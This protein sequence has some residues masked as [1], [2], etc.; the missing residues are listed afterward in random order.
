MTLPTFIRF[1]IRTP[2]PQL[3]RKTTTNGRMEEDL[4]ILY[5]DLCNHWSDIP[6]IL[7]LSSVDQTKINNP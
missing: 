4:K 7:N 3:E 2:Q 5:V 1:P 6:Q